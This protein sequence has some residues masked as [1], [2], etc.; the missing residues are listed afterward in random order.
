MHILRLPPVSVDYSP[1]YQ[2]HKCDLHDCKQLCSCF[3]SVLLCI[4]VSHKGACLT[5]GC[6][7]CSSKA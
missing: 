5:R 3:V 7:S 2:Q 1:H 4:D 6:V